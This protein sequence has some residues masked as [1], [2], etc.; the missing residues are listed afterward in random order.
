MQATTLSLES[1]REHAD[2]A[3][4]YLRSIGALDAMVMFGTFSSALYDRK[5]FPSNEDDKSLLV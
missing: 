4:E 1:L 2:N 3:H 5:L